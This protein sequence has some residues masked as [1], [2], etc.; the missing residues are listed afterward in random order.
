[1]NLM[2]LALND[3]HNR[4]RGILA[5]RNVQYAPSGKEFENFDAVASWTGFRPEQVAFWYMSKHID[6]VRAWIL[7]G[8]DAEHLPLDSFVDIVNYLAIIYAMTK[9]AGQFEMEAADTTQADGAKWPGENGAIT[10]MPDQWEASIVARLKNLHRDAEAAIAEAVK[11]KDEFDEAINWGDLHVADVQLCIGVNGEWAY[12]VEIE[13]ATSTTG[14]FASF[15]LE[16]LKK[17]G[18]EDYIE[19]YLEW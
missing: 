5:E 11:H 16:F 6:R 12:R 13:E 1:M 19:V 3:L 10:V 7:S 4:C 14:K 18:W 9:S 2:V 17:R 15:I 8:A